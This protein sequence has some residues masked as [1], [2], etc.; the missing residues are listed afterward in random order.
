MLKKYT[1]EAADKFVADNRENVIADYRHHYHMM[2]PVGW[3][4]DPNGFVFYNG[5][6]HLFFQYYPYDSSWGPMH[7]GHMKSK[8]LIHWEELPTALA[9]DQPYDKDV[10]FSGSSI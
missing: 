7:W 3:M 10:C 6:Y 1:L 8:D 4:N 9:P 5:E 2:A